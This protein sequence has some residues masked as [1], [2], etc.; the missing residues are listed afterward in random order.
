MI[1]KDVIIV[2]GGP[3]GSACA[4]RLIKTGASCLVLDQQPFPRFK[5]CAGW[6]TPELVKD[7]ELRL[8]DYPYGLTT[9]RSFDIA[10]RSLKF[11]L[12]TRQYAIRRFEFDDFLLRRSGAPV[13]Q[14]TVKSINVVADGYQIDGEF[15]AQYLVGAGG[16]HCPVNRLL[17]EPVEPRMKG[18]LI[19]AQEEEFPYPY[20]DDRCRLWFLQN[21]LPGYAWYVPKANGY[22]NI[23][24]GGKMEQL[25]ANGDTL[26]RHWNLLVEK[27]D[28]MGLV[29][30]HEYH[31]S[32]HSYY[33]RQNRTEIRRGNAFLTGD[34]LGL[35]TLDMG[36]GI[37]P[38]VKS[39]LQAAD[40]I[41]RGTQ[42]SIKSI[43]KYSLWS[44]IRL[45]FS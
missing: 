28:R 33:L 24:V 19:V 16:T 13:Q 20:T 39:G 7:L 43:P 34:S 12:P 44:L 22:L 15:F 32:G 26:K 37:H 38:A 10:I 42:Y 31:P 4:W 30:N 17:Y 35:A 18:S 36:E 21:S 41:L 6:I 45:R 1:K 8:T 2:G 11:R 14:H 23:G 29:R 9:F 5:P 25:K 27:L 3:A 40:A